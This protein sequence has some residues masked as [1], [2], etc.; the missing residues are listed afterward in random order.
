MTDSESKEIQVK[1]KREL[2]SLA[3]QTKPGPAFTPAVDILEN[4][5]EILLMADMPGVKPA[6]LDIDLREG[7][8]TIT[9][10]VAPA[11][12]S[13]EEEVLV[14][15]ETGRFYRQFSLSEAIDQDRIDAKLK[16]GVLHL[17]LPKVARA[18]PRRIEVQAG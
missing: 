13:K 6:D 17:V 9:G 5:K 15:Y 10:D 2:A 12:E 14:E 16:D 18:V 1:E 4:E 8:L 7:T 3:E 11:V